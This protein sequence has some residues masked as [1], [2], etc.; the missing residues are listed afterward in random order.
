MQRQPAA[1]RAQQAASNPSQAL[2]ALLVD[3]S[4][5]T[6]AA[7]AARSS[8]SNWRGGGTGCRRS[9]AHAG[10]WRSVNS[11]TA[12]RLPEGAGGGR[13]GQA[14]LV[15]VG[16]ACAGQPIVRHPQLPSRALSSPAAA[17]AP[18]PCSW[19]AASSPPPSDWPHAPAGIAG[20][21]QKMRGRMATRPRGERL[22]WRGGPMAPTLQV[23]PGHLPARNTHTRPH[24][25]PCP[26]PGTC[27]H[28][29]GRASP[30]QSRT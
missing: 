27:P 25:R 11:A 20:R 15:G 18:H 16:A 9:I 1:A 28:P 8:G 17:G 30:C 24:S 21:G 19:P 3:G 7:A 6:P 4:M 29:V 12:G 23:R 5:L 22:G 10:K 2:R 14:N 13:W 26:A